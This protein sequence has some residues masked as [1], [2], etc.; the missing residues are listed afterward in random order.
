M[1]LILAVNP[2][3]IHTPTLSRLA[4]ELHGCE[5]IGAE[6]C[7][8]AIRA[9]DERVPDLILMPASAPRGETELLARLLRVPGG[10]PTLKLPPP[11]S[12]DPL[13][14][15]TEIRALLTGAPAAPAA[16]V[17]SP[18]VIAAANAAISWIRARRNAWSL[19]PQPAIATEAPAAAFEMEPA[20]F[21]PGPAPSLS[22][23]IPAHADTSVGPADD[24]LSVE[25]TPSGAPSWLP[26]AAVAAVVLA[27][28]GAAAVFWPSSRSST[29]APEPAAP[30]S[31]AHTPSPATTP[32]ATAQP[33]QESA[34]PAVA[35]WVA[36]FAPFEIIIT[37]D[38]KPV[39]LDDRNRALLSAGRHRL[40]FA[41]QALGYEE[42]RTV[43]IKPTET[44]T[45]NL[46]P[47]AIVRVKASEPA[48]VL[49]DG[50]RAGEVPFEGSVTLGTHTVTV[51]SSGG[52][53]QFTI[54]A[55]SK[56]TV[57]EADFS[58]P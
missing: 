28:A 33:A 48:E 46:N 52:E 40:R 21:E 57:L 38:N 56:P 22:P 18:H 43:A 8:V 6:S 45:I 50:T 15:A 16:P 7:A 49:I 32:P 23:A 54:Q 5:L 4:R 1:A 51:R 12:A 24:A 10:V 27:I 37:E 58:K 42:T 20:I 29:G 25:E 35:G 44:V 3:N 26:K 53:R 36:V 9:I 34:D 13:S 17:T 14:L 31:S 30:T 11:V 41:N 55:T 39:L 2:G 19:E 47:K